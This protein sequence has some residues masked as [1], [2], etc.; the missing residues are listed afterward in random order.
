MKILPP[1]CTRERV[2]WGERSE[3][4]DMQLS[5]M[6]CR[7]LPKGTPA[8]SRKQIVEYL[9]QIPGWKLKRG[10]IEKTFSFKNFYET[11]AFVNAMAFIANSQN[12]HPD[13]EVG[14]NKCSVKYST[15]SVGGLSK[16]D[17]ICAARIEALFV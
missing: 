5:Q 9:K 7:E 16:N 17:F 4:F 1:P 10:V 6:K 14:Y 11:I 15:H 2:G 8:L 12:H 3:Y 13:L